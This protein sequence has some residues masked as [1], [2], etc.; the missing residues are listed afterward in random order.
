MQSRVESDE[1]KMG[2]TDLPSAVNAG[3][4]HRLKHMHEEFCIK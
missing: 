3:T 2:G 4:G 1:D